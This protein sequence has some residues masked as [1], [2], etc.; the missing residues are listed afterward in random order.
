MTDKKPAENHS[1]AISCPHSTWLEHANF[2][3]QRNWKW[4][5]VAGCITGTALAVGTYCAITIWHGENLTQM[6]VLGFV[7]MLIALN[8]VAVFAAPTRESKAA[9]TWMIRAALASATDDERAVLYKQLENFAK[10]G[11]RTR[12]LSRGELFGLFREARQN[13]GDRVKRKRQHIEA[14]RDM[15][16]DVISAIGDANTHAS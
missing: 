6:N 9:P 16:F 13:Y 15:Q 4:T 3:M 10:S 14:E 12:P 2:Y 11:R 1:P 7:L 8:H 5:T